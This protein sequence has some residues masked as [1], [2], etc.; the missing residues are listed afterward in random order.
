MRNPFLKLNE[1]GYTLIITLLVL[2]VLSILG[3]SMLGISAN[4]INNMTNERDTQS[5]YYIAE[6]GLVE[7]RAELYS[8][9]INAVN[10]FRENYEK[11]IIKYKDGIIESSITEGI[12]YDAV[13]SSIKTGQYLPIKTFEEHFDEPNP[14]AIVT[15]SYNENKKSFLLSSTGRIGEK[16]RT[17]S[18][19]I[20]VLFDPKVIPII[21]TDNNNNRLNACY[22]LYTS[23]AITT[24]SGTI[25]GDIYS[26]EKLT[27][28]NNGASLN[29]NLFSSED[30]EINGSSGIRNVFSKKNITISGGNINGNL[31]AENNITISGYPTLNQNLIAKNIYI[32]SWFDSLKGKYKYNSS[33]N[34][35]PIG[36]STNNSSK[37]QKISN[38]EFNTIISTYGFTNSCIQ[39][40]PKLAATSEVFKLPTNTSKPENKIISGTKAYLIKDG[41]LN[42][43]DSIPN[44]T[45]LE[46]VSDLYFT[47]FNIANDRTLNIDLKGGNRSIYIDSLNITQ[48]H[49]NI[50][51]PGTLKIYVLNNMWVGG[52]STINNNGKISTSNIYYSGKSSLSIAGGVTLNNSLHVKD[53]NLTLSGGGRVN[54]DIYGYGYNTIKVDGGTSV[55]EQLFLAPYSS[56]IHSGGGTINGN[57]VAKTY[58]L[59]GGAT[60]NPPTE[61]KPIEPEPTNPDELPDDS[62]NLLNPLP[63]KEE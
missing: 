38:E 29:G 7:K 17:I 30:I 53:A 8:Q 4:T 9:M 46:V 47:N 27:I 5:V 18:Q 49:I 22:A 52:G 56:F 42:F 15:L 12:Y 44:N 57:V 19:E 20:E 10:L 33:I 32:N 61:S 55:V 25:N 11:E 24:G 63:P 40:V 51:N 14:E 6:A 37:I 35:N 43:N 39:Q 41:S 48:G 16:K 2:I 58:N 45:T 28:G 1:K 54:G 23:G 59:S 62:Y 26:T 50:V 34:F 36:N 60:I 21:N 13:K 31:I 3:I